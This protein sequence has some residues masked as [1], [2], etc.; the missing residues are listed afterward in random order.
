MSLCSVDG[1]HDV[2]GMVKKV[3]QVMI[4]RKSQNQFIQ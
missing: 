4:T 2:T 1:F 3:R